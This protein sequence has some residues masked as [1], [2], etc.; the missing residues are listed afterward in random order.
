MMPSPPF[1]ADQDEGILTRGD[2]VEVLFPD[3]SWKPAVVYIGPWHEVSIPDGK[4]RVLYDING[5]DDEG[6]FHGRFDS[7]H[8][9]RPK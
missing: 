6:S 7:D 5:T 1:I 9:R 2:A 3:G 8:V 4:T